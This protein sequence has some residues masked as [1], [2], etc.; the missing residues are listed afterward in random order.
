M[1][2]NV[3]ESTGILLCGG[4][5]TR[6][7]PITSV[8]NKHLLPV[9]S[10]PMLYYPLSILLLLRIKKI[11]IVCNQKDLMLL[12]QQLHPITQLGVQIRFVVQNEPLGIVDAIEVAL[13]FVETEIVSVLLGD[14]IFTGANLSSYLK[15]ALVSITDCNIFTTN[16]RNPEHFGI[17]ERDENAKIIKL[18]EKP[19]HTLSREAITGFYSFSSEFLRF[20]LPKVVKSKRNER[21]IIDV[22]NIACE[23]RVLTSNLLPRGISWFD[24][25]TIDDS[26]QASVFIRST[27]N[28]S[29]EYLCAPEEII[30][31]NGWVDKEKFLSVVGE[32]PI[33]HYKDYLIKVALI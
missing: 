11:F 5:G 8:I 14:N 22:F 21:E 13:P 32:Y 29:G 2:M 19:T 27:E 3:S 20:Y 16:V 4:R 10:K 24:A 9:A 1:S 26:Y 18:T 17:V 31:R 30:Y 6:L 15:K 28:R 25:G 33:G 12:E 23:T 7:F